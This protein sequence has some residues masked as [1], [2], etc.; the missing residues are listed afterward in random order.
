MPWILILVFW[1]KRYRAALVLAVTYGICTLTRELLEPRLVGAHLKILPVVVLASVY[2]G[3]KVYGL[4]GDRAGAVIGA[5]DSRIVEV[6]L[7][8]IRTSRRFPSVYG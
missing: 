8:N 1:Q 6:Y 4:G 7:R 2:V 5:G 3:V